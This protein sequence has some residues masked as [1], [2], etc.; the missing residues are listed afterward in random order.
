MMETEIWTYREVIEPIDIQG[1]EVE[2][3]DG[4]IGK[5]DEATYNVGSSYVVV[6]TGPWI[7]G[8]KVMIPAGAIE[9]IDLENRK[10]SVRLAKDQI[11]NSPAYDESTYKDDQ[12][13]SDLGT[14]YGP[15]I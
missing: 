3:S 14:Y 15:L 13:R 5:I 12:Y 10:V 9:M 1:F 8:R 11:K 7:F 4:H 2:A 6:D